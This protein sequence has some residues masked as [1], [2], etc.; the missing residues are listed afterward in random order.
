VIW[1]IA[2]LIAFLGV[3]SVRIF[4]DGFRSA[5]IARRGLNAWKMFYTLVSLAGF[6]L[7]IW[8]YGQARLDHVFMRTPPVSMRYATMVLTLLAFILIA[9]AYVPGNR[10]KAAVGH[11][12]V[13]GVKTW[14]FG[15]LLSAF[16]LAGLVLFG[17]FFV[18][19]IVDYM[20]LRRRDRA[21]GVVYPPGSGARDVLTCA[22]GTIAW[23]VFAFWLHG[24]LIGV[25]LFAS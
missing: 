22:V 17:T 2:G 15:H 12:M 23:F 16:S 3:H 7:I 11:P 1:L 25:A 13:A 6:A 14:A 8:G 20:S 18:W 9:A 10:I 4:A 21:A 19:A 5:Q 24:P